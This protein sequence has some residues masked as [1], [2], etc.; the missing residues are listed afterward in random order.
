MRVMLA[1]LT[2]VSAAP[3]QSAEK[4]SWGF[5]RS[6]KEAHLVYGVPETEIV[7]LSFVCE[8]KRIEIISTVLPRSPRKGQAARPH[9]PTV[10]PPRPMAVSS[11]RRAKDFTFKRTRRLSRRLWTS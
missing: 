3:A 8:G 2:V 5:V 7:T 6:G 11:A 10:P 4:E 9:S 1:A